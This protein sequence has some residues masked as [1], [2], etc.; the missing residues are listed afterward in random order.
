L[1]AIPATWLDTRL[2]QDEVQKRLYDRKNVSEASRQ[3][4][5]ERVAQRWLPRLLAAEA[6]GDPFAI[7]IL[8]DCVALPELLRPE[9]DSTC[10][11][12]PE[13]RER[14]NHLLE[15]SSVGAVV[16]RLRKLAHSATSVTVALDGCP[17]DDERC[18]VQAATQVLHE[19]QREVV[20]TGILPP[21]KQ[22]RYQ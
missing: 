8:H 13:V 1:P 3:K 7:W 2:L 19:L 20:D 4:A 14:A 10:S 16:S 21:L 15:S 18:N 11:E 9:I 22:D 17:N 12:E 5:K 6:A